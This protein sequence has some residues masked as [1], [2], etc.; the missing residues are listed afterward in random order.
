MT[1]KIYNIFYQLGGDI[2][3]DK[4]S[5]KI[6]SGAGVLL[7]EKINNRWALILIEDHTKTY[8]DSGGNYESKHNNLK[9]TA[10][11]ELREES[12]N[13]IHIKN[14]EILINYVD[15]YYQGNNTFY[16][17]YILNIDDINENEFL[18]NVNII[19]NSIND[20]PMFWKETHSL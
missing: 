17:S 9:E 2:Y 8:S 20:V 7:L 11:E 18:N 5:D 12:R 14:P 3:L 19:D 16:R 13:L 1:K 6:F 15:T 10:I 4:D